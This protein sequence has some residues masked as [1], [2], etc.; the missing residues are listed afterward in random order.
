MLDLTLLITAEIGI[1][2]T[3]LGKRS[4]TMKAIILAA[5][6]AT[7]LYPLTLH[8]PK[9]LLPIA[10]KPILDYIVEE[11]VS[12]P[13]MKEILVVS[14][15]R[16]ADQ[17]DAWKKTASYPVPVSIINDGTTSDQ[18]KLGAI[19]DIQLVL[20]KV[21]V[22]EDLFVIAGDTFFTFPLLDFY[23]YYEAIRKDC[24]L[25]KT[26]SD[27]EQLRRMGVVEINQ[28]Q[29]VI[30]F[31]EKPQNPKSDKASFAGYIYRQD[32][33]PLF[34][35]YLEQGR[36]PDAPGHFPAWLHTLKEVY[37][38]PFEG[39]C[40]DI[41]TPESYQEVNDLFRSGRSD[42]MRHFRGKL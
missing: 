23:R 5:G 42:K 37:A 14:N 2:F 11:L 31:E 35:V 25:V 10:D 13:V 4:E 29:Q 26:I 20:S 1:L 12:I 39:E 30:G 24:F 6:Y 17:F 41:G 34:R 40:Y 19:G 28:I 33:L 3:I 27:T 32:T 38:Y 36:N 21:P 7:R 16:F 18:N 22:E 15:H 8:V 9:A